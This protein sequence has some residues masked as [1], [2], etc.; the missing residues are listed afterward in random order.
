MEREREEIKRKIEQS[1]N[2][3]M[4]VQV[5]IH[6]IKT[7]SEEKTGKEGGREGGEGWREIERENTT[8]SCVCT[9]TG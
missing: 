8:S 4:R 5:H 7:N 9:I 1:N 2:N 3:K 6:I